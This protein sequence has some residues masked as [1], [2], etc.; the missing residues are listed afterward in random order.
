MPEKLK[1]LLNQ[2]LV[3]SLV[4]SIKL[5]HKQFDANGLQNL[6]IQVGFRVLFTPVIIA[7]EHE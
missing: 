3:S 6:S 5:V 2:T 1:H 4:R 7:G